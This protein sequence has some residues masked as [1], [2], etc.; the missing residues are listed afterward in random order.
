MWQEGS[1]HL[2]GFGQKVMLFAQCGKLK[3]FGWKILG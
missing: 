2:G 3:F 1:A